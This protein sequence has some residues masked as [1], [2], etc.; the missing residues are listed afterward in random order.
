MGPIRRRIMKKFNLKFSR[1]A[2]ERMQQRGLR[3]ND[4]K[5][6]LRFGTQI[7]NDVTLLSNKDTD[8][9]I[10]HRKREI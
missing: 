3:E 8:R 5:F 2:D 1:H 6:I 7:D 9:E 4:I 10:R